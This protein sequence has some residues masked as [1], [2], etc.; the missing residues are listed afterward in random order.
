[1][2]R[3][4]VT[5]GADTQVDTCRTKRLLRLIEV[6]T[7][8]ATVGKMRRDT[9][10]NSEIRRQ[11]QIEDVAKFARRQKEWIDRGDWANDVK[12]IKIV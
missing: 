7:L 3:P 9:I 11:C 6:R 5:Y 8:R 12:L 2:V 10:R 1:M 4:V